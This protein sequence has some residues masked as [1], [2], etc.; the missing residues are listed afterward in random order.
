MNDFIELPRTRR[1]QAERLATTRRQLLDSA[2][3]Y[4]GS[5]GYEAAS[6]VEILEHAGLTRGALYHHFADKR[7]LFL[8]VAAEVDV[9]ISGKASKGVVQLKSADQRL[10]TGLK[11][12]LEGLVEPANAQILLLDGPSVIG[13]QNVTDPQKVH[14]IRAFTQLIADYRPQDSQQRHVILAD[15][16]SAMVDRTALVI[17]QSPD[18][19]EKRQEYVDQMFVLVKRSLEMV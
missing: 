3:L 16:L 6:T 18:H 4:F 5:Q 14:S 2:R 7:S 8:A 15:L 13:W 10:L 12:Y 19:P 9:E 1:T 11:I 17:A